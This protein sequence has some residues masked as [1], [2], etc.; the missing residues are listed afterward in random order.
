MSANT[1]RYE[2]TEFQYYY[3]ETDDANFFFLIEDINDKWIV[4]KE[5]IQK[6][7]VFIRIPSWYEVHEI[8]RLSAKENP[9]TKERVPVPEKIKDNKLKLLLWKIVDHTGEVFYFNK[10]NIEN[11]HPN[12][13]N[14]FLKKINEL[15]ER[16]NCFSGLTDE[17]ER[18]LSFECF[19]Y[20][21]AL[22]KKRLGR[23]VKI[24][25]P[26]AIVVLKRICEMFNCLPDEAR[27]IS[28]E[29][30]DKVFIANEQEYYCEDPKNVGIVDKKN[31]MGAR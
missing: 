9:Y 24:P 27:K 28:K 4:D 21:S 30:I 31:H 16:E 18:D 13:A 7:K 3:S 22:R 26:P 25:I 14:F 19:K 23:Q 5:K 15:I 12:L 1:N 10:E 20:Y 11:L 2:E 29:D 17:E 6:A 8:S